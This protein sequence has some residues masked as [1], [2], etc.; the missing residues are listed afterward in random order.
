L[1]LEWADNFVFWIDMILTFHCAYKNEYDEMV[2]SYK[3]IFCNY[4][5]GWFLVDFIANVPLDFLFFIL[6]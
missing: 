3:E 1:V 5:H 6:G 2:D 4:L